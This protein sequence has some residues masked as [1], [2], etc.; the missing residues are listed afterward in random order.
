MRDVERAC[1]IRIRSMLTDNGEAFTDC[2]FGLSKRAATG[3]H[4][5]DILCSTLGIEQRLIHQDRRKPTE[6]S[7]GSTAASRTCYKATIFDQAKSWGQRSIADAC[8]YNQQLP[9]LALGGK[10]PL[11]VMKH[12]CKI[13]LKLFKTQP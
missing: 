8:L 3:R 7:S 5:F 6:W 4:E 13:K 9:Q 1:P 12:W 10:T 11:Q 2:P